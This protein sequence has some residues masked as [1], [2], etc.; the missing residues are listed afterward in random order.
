MEKTAET[1]TRTPNEQLCVSWSSSQQICPP[2]TKTYLAGQ[3]PR[4]VFVEKPPPSAQT[5]QMGHGATGIFQPIKWAPDDK[6]GSFLYRRRAG[7][8]LKQSFSALFRAG[9]LAH[10][11]RPQT[12]ILPSFLS[13]LLPVTLS[14]FNRLFG[15]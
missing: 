1:L 9:S 10:L 8:Y 5:G 12:E 6:T 2:G 7:S 13:S 3:Q 14:L 11:Q 15:I 4:A